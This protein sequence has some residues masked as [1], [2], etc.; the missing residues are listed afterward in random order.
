[1]PAAR[2]RPAGF[3]A[4]AA[5]G[6]RPSPSAATSAACPASA[7]ARTDRPARSRL[8]A[9]SPG[10]MSA[11][12]LSARSTTARHSTGGTL[13][14]RVNRRGSASSYSESKTRFP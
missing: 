4:G 3:V 1:M 13:P 6:T 10:T 8:V 5:V 2:E 14:S 12:A 7:L 9:R 11:G